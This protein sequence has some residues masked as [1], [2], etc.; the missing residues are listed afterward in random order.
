MPTT[1][2]PAPRRRWQMQEAK[3]KLAEVIRRAREEGPQTITVH[4]RE[5]VIVVK[6][7]DYDTP[8]QKPRKRGKPPK[9]QSLW[10]VLAPLR[11]LNIEFERDRSGSREV[12]FADWDEKDEA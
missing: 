11:G 6:A 1:A 5:S 12:P 9:G 4:G 8:A 10:D 3:N 2:K 7:E